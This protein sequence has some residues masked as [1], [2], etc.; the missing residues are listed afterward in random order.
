MTVKELI[1]TLQQLD[2]ELHVFTRGYESGLEYVNRPE[3][4]VEVVL[5]YYN[6]EEW[7]YGPH[8]VAKNIDTRDDVSMHKTV[9]GIV[10]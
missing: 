8:E 1:D 10:L 3:K 4:T 2:P 6:S 9:K 7:W 5:D